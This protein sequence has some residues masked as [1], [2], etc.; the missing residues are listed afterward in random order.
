MYWRW[1]RKEGLVSASQAYWHYVFWLEFA[2]VTVLVIGFIAVRRQLSFNLDALP[3]LGRVFVPASLAVFGAEHLDSAKDIM[4]LVPAW[5]P[6]RLFWA[7]FV[8]FALIAAAISI[9]LMKYVR[10]SAPLLGT[11]LL[12]F[13]LMIHIP[14][15]VATPH[16]RFRWAVAARDLVFSAGAWAL[17][18]TQMEG[19]H[20]QLAHRLIAGCRAVFAAVLLFFGI[21]HLL[22]PQ[23]LPGVPLEQLTLAWIPVRSLWGYFVG[24]LLLASGV[25]LL[26]NKQ[27]RTA[28]T[29]L[30]IAITLVVL[31]I[32]T[33]LLVVAAKPSEM[34][35]A[36]NYIADT[37]LFA[38]SIFLLAR[39][40]PATSGSSGAIRQAA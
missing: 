24:V 22:H 12:L 25:S 15:V 23:N 38:G 35:T 40:L 9:T 31:L 16:D 30:G 5:M 3:I 28:A 1:S 17:A 2:G 34:T 27:A 18:G 7:Y 14:S 8:G 11:M 20:P 32:Y 21:E 4:Q 19:R 36:I 6:A 39:A 33:P 37:L 29:W 13:V 26:I 10:L